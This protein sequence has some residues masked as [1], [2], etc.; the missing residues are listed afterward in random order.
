L[1]VVP[2]SH[3]LPPLPSRPIGGC[4]HLERLLGTKGGENCWVIKG[5]VN[6]SDG[7]TQVDLSP[8]SFSRYEG[9][10]EVERCH[11]VDTRQKTIKHGFSA[12]C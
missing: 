5:L 6:I 8:E 2:A 1:V 10:W 7:I 9:L 3:A 12:N 11:A 4:V